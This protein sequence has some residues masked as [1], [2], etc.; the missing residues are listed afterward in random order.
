M[1]DLRA[2]SLREADEAQ[3]AAF[4]RGREFGLLANDEQADVLER[5]G[6]HEIWLADEGYPGQQAFVRY[7]C[8]VER[9]GSI[10]PKTFERGY[11]VVEVSF[12]LP[13]AHLGHFH[14]VGEGVQ[15]LERMLVSAAFIVGVS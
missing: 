5:F 10:P 2:C 6:C 12:W 9:I 4:N 1:H 13:V 3:T 7:S 11:H 15:E 8:P 14:R